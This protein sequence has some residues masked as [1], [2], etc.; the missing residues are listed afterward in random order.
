M[1][2]HQLFVLSRLEGTID[3]ALPQGFFN[4]I[5][6]LHQI[7]GVSENPLQSYVWHYPPGNIFGKPLSISTLY[8]LAMENGYIIPTQAL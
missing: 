4:D 6:K 1:D 5:L 3:T 7:Y 8:A 2:K